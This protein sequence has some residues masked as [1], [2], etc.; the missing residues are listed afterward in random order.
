MS[1][2]YQKMG[3]GIF[4][5]ISTVFILILLSIVVDNFLSVIVFVANFPNDTIFHLFKVLVIGDSN[6]GKSSLLVRFCD[7]SFSDAFIS[8]IGVDFKVKTIEMNNKLIK[9]QVA[10]IPFFTYFFSF[11][12]AY[13]RFSST[14]GAL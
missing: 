1:L 13:C 5:G 4:F 8:T 3:G 14:G 10:H 2:N 9:L 12:L 11:S 6:A 7:H